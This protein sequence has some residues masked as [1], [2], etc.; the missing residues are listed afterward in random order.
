MDL[1]EVRDPM[2]HP[3]LQAVLEETEEQVEEIPL[4]DTRYTG[5]PFAKAA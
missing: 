1:L 2:H 4:P 3:V 5:V